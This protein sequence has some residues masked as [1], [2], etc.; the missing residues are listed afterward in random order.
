M[1]FKRENLGKQVFEEKGYNPSTDLQ[2][3]LKK[4]YKALPVWHLILSLSL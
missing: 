4:M 1:F 3:S 2:K